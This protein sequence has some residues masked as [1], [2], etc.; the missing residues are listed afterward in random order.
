MNFAH[1]YQCVPLTLAVVHTH[2][3]THTRNST[4]NTLLWVIS[5]PV[6]LLYTVP[7]INRNLLLVR[8]IHQK[9]E[10]LMVTGDLNTRMQPN[11]RC[12]HTCRWRI[13]EQKCPL[14]PHIHSWSTNTQVG[15]HKHCIPADSRAVWGA[16]RGFIYAHRHTV[17][18]QAHTS[19]PWVIKEASKN[20][21][22]IALIPCSPCSINNCSVLVNL[23]R[24]SRKTETGCSKDSFLPHWS[25]C[26]FPAF[27]KCFFFFFLPRRSH[28][29]QGFLVQ[30]C[31]GTS[32][33]PG[34]LRRNLQ[35][36]DAWSEFVIDVRHDFNSSYAVKSRSNN[37]FGVDDVLMVC[38]LKSNWNAALIVVIRCLFVMFS[39]IFWICVL[40]R[41]FRLFSVSCVF[42]PFV[43]SPALFSPHLFVMSLVCLFTVFVLPLV[44]VS[45]YCDVRHSVCPSG[46]PFDMFL[47]SLFLVLVWTWLELLCILSGLL[48]GGSLILCIFSAFC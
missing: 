17:Y 29:H 46:L 8:L 41:L 26:S 20:T 35:H 22:G 36:V 3:H 2:T 27:L 34:N 40:L 33:Q 16:G 28:P 10:E 48:V 14:T 9:R 47:V 32:R 43:T 19:T 6:L 13:S 5:D 39:L 38:T 12:S 25:F 1:W 30:V 18:A 37:K 44:L 45:S 24:Q 31:V 11:K 4:T 15:T 7:K 21:T 23:R 42:S